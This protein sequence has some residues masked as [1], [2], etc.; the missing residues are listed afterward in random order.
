MAERNVF[1]RII[2]QLN[3]LVFVIKMMHYVVE[4]YYFNIA[5]FSLNRPKRKCC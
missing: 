2:F 3:T 5:I 1:L 4:K